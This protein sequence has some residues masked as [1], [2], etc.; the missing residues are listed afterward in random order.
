MKLKKTFKYVFILIEKICTRLPKCLFDFI[1]KPLTNITLPKIYSNI[2]RKTE[3][4]QLHATKFTDGK[5][6][7]CGNSKLNFILDFNSPPKTALLIDV[8]CLPDGKIISEKEI[9]IYS[10]VFK[11]TSLYSLCEASYYFYEFSPH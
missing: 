11:K 1:H 9:S 3:I 2:N 6:F 4:A 7:P 10:S 8:F 5:T